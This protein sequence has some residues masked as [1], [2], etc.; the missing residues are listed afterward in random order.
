MGKLRG[1][2]HELLQQ[3]PNLTDLN[4]LE[5]Y[6]FLNAK[7]N[8]SSGSWIFCRPSLITFQKWKLFLRERWD[9]V[10]CS[11]ARLNIR[12]NA[13]VP[14]KNGVFYR[15]LGY[16]SSCLRMSETELVSYLK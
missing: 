12:I 2:E 5:I 16:I 14:K 6:L 13:F 3:S 7:K 9:K 10:H 8:Y 4:P 15:Q 11:K 1:T